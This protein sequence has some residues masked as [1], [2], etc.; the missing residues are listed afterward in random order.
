MTPLSG[1]FQPCGGGVGARGR[2]LHRNKLGE[3]EHREGKTGKGAKERM[4]KCPP[5]LSPEMM[6]SLRKVFY[7]LSIYFK[8]HLREGH[9][10][11]LGS[12]GPFKIKKDEP[13]AC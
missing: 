6:F 9:R 4:N 11:R 3:T 8:L 13:S 7:N 12:G 2:R 5:S 1:T 10:K